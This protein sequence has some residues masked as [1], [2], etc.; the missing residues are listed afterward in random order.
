MP[1]AC[2]D[3]VSRPLCTTSAGGGG[4]TATTREA[5]APTL[6]LCRSDQMPGT[7]APCDPRCHASFS[8]CAECP[9]PPQFIPEPCP[10]RV[11]GLLEPEETPAHPSRGVLVEHQSRGGARRWGSW[12]PHEAGPH[13]LP[14]P[15]FLSPHPHRLQ[16][17]AL[18]TVSICVPP[19]PRRPAQM[20]LKVGLKP[21]Q[22]CHQP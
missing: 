22:F 7:W 21:R 19:S 12:E 3:P 14:G 1:T 4:R 16:T 20:S 11:A 13:G 10:G 5:F 9:S 6:A 18:C 17:P 8:C 2:S 15:L